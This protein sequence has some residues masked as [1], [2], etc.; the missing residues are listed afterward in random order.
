MR[1]HFASACGLLAVLYYACALTADAKPPGEW[2][3]YWI[4]RDSEYYI[5]LDDGYL[6][7]G[8][9]AVVVT[10]REKHATGQ[11]WFVNEIFNCPTSQYVLSSVAETDSK[12]NAI[13]RWKN[14]NVS[15]SW[16]AVSISERQGA[17]RN[18]ICTGIPGRPAS[19]DAARAY[20]KDFE[21]D[22]K[23]IRDGS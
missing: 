22:V 14:E 1:L 23:T 8:N 10:V 4:D 18:G 3:L 15:D 21:K 9:N 19:V 16:K 2:Y 11:T 17:L 12:G 7:R 5:S 13:N 20:F 6:I